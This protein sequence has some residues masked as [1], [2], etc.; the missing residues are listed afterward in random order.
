MIPSFKD[1]VAIVTGAATGIGE[2][3]AR[4]LASRG[5]RLLLMDKDGE[6]AESVA[7]AIRGQ[8][9]HALVHRADVACLDDHRA[10]IDLALRTFGALHYA[11]NNAGISGPLVPLHELGVEEW[12]RTVAVDLDAIFYGMKVQ[13][14]AIEAA[15]GGAIVN[16]A[17]I[18]AHLGLVRR[19]AYTACKHAVLGLTRSVAIEY[20]TRN[21]RI[22]AVS[23]GPIRTPLMMRD[24]G[25]AELF[26]ALTAMKRIGEAA[27]LAKTVAFLLSDDASFVTGSELIVDG[28][29]SLS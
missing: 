10:A 14:P 20:A 18:Y 3:V 29:V 25:R 23:P 2:A 4:E 7:G 6:G 22:N 26:A 21:I 9:G 19:D 24:P 27:E 13:L 5:T 1:K 17:S 12:H 16:I 11:V 15:G 8:G 28:G